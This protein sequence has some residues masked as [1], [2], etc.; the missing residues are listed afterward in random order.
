MKDDCANIPYD[1]GPF[2]ISIS[3]RSTVLLKSIFEHDYYVDLLKKI[4]IKYGI[5]L[6]GEVADFELHTDDKLISVWNY[7]WMALPDSTE[8]RRFPFFE[9]CNLCEEIYE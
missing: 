2:R 4:F 7:F 6:D 1:E 5:A 8:I 9:L 3:T